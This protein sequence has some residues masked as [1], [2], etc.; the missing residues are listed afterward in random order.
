[1]AFAVSFSD[2]AIQCMI[3]TSYLATGGTRRPSATS[4]RVGVL[5]S[6]LVNWRKDTQAEGEDKEMID[7]ESP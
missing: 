3:D 4:N 2:G 5:V 7:K 6:P 1:M